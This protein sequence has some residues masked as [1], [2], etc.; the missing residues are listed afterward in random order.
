M[1]AETNCSGNPY[2]VRAGG[3]RALGRDLAR[4]VQYFL[5]CLDVAR[6]RRR[7]LALDESALKDIGRSRVDAFREANRG[8]WDIPEDLKSRR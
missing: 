7:L 4:F 8:F 5:I 6:Q 2:P 1:S 3:V